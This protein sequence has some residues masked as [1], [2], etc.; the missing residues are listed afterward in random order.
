MFR[1]LKNHQIVSRAMALIHT[2]N[3]KITESHFHEQNQQNQHSK[4]GIP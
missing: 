2:N 3:P 1:P 4:Q